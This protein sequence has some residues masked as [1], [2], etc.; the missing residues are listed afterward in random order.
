MNLVEANTGSP[1][2]VTFE[3]LEQWCE[4]AAAIETALNMGG[5]PGMDL[6]ISRAAEWNEAVD[7]WTAGLQTCLEL[8]S[9][10][11]R[12]E[13]MQW[14]AED[15]LAAGDALR[16][17]TQ[18]DGWADWQATLEEQQVPVPRFDDDLRK[19]V[20]NLEQELKASD[21]A[22]RSLREQIDGLRRNALIRGDLGERLTLLDSIRSL[23][24]NREIWTGMIAPIRRLRAER[25]EAEA[26]AALAARD[27]SLLARKVEEVRNVD[28]EGQLPGTVVA[29]VNAAGHLIKCRDAIHALSESAAQV[30]M[31]SRELEGQ[32]LNLPAFGALLRTALQARQNYLGIRQQLSQSLQ[33]AASIPETKAAVIA[34]KLV[35]QGKQIDATVK[36]SLTWL[37]QQEQFE[38]LRLQF[39]AKEDDIQKLIAMA[40]SSGG[41]WEETKRKAARWLELESQLRIVVNRL[42][43]NSPDFV[44]PSTAACLAE[45]EA[46]RKAV[47]AD[48]D[49][50]VLTEKLVIGAVIGG[51]ILVLLVIFG[52]VFL[53]A[54]T[55]PR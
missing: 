32:P 18:R 12:D 46:C 52:L 20:L 45:L 26:R 27:F 15:F 44:P 4:I 7:E 10:G 21:I 11:L 22:G 5:E 50:V 43:A 53:S 3:R 28:W 42:C 55:S 6:L 13:A 48:R 47:R 14:H 35:D 41:S 8:G 37:G 49:R 16:A 40:P 39:C 9:R 30:G 51:L 36:P 34:L 29:L 23:D 54:A 24:G 2:A 38:R 1:P 17:P 25:I 19:L 31:R 33:H